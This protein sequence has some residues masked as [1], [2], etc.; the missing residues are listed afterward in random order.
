MRTKLQLFLFFLIFITNKANSQFVYENINNEIYEYLARMSQ[1]GLV[2]F[3]DL[4]KPIPRETIFNKLQELTAKS[5][6]LTR[7][8]N[9]ELAFYL[10]EY[11]KSNIKNDKPI[12]YL[13]FKAKQPVEFFSA[14]NDNIY[15]SASPVIQY[16]QNNYK[17]KLFTEKAIGAQLWGR[18]GKHIGFN[19]FARD[20]TEDLFNNLNDS[21]INYA[22]TGYVILNEKSAQQ[23]Q[24][25]YS[26]YRASIGYQWK[27][28]FVS[29]G[30]DNSTWGYGV[31]GKIVLSEKSPF[32]QYI[33]LHYQPFSW[34]KF[35]YMHTWLNSNFVDSANSYSYGNDVYGGTRLNYVPKFMANHSI[36]ITPKK[37][38]DFSIGE[39]II[40][41]EKLDLGF[42][43]PLMYYKLYDN[44]KSNY[45]IMNGNNAHLYF[46]LSMKNIIPNAHLYTTLFIDEIKV[47]KIFDPNKSRNQLGFNIGL[48]LN[49]ILINYLSIYSEYTRA[50]PFVYN[51]INPAQNYTSYGFN[52]GDWV[53]NNFD[54]KIIG[55]KYTPISRLKLDF[56]FQNIRK[57]PSYSIN[58][59]YLQQPQK[60]FLENVI[61]TQT[62]YL[63][64]ASY[65]LMNNIYLLGDCNS[66]S[67]RN[68]YYN[69]IAKFNNY[70]LG[71]KIGL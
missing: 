40:Y 11:S 55:I 14:Q 5:S 69:T 17:G 38:I 48:N 71:F 35:D 34:L 63:F 8:E 3:D 18:I 39:S 10:K 31:N 22:Q 13:R 32:N 47:S 49:D 26:E 60:R 16:T 1:K 2:E 62:E 9:D 19:I 37:G 61:Y 58:D 7:I 20:V 28:G 59:Q 15:L 27:N 56:R 44:N 43:F 29:I 68:E 21:I 36:T 6:K 52:L 64:K 12:N 54:R 30:Q 51:N 53:G 42:L 25:N 41:T 65:E 50:N 45:H 33:R 70:S 66:T 46:Q 24:I 57:G 23:K 67:T 4:I